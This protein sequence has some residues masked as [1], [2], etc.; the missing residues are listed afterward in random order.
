MGCENGLGSSR[1]VLNFLYEED[2]AVMPTFAN[3]LGPQMF[4]MAEEEFG[5]DWK[6]CCTSN[7]DWS[8]ISPWRLWV[9]SSCVAGLTA[10]ATK[11]LIAARCCYR[12]NNCWTRSAGR[13]CAQSS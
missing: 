10:F 1:E 6:N 8:F 12:K 7:K 13:P 4:W 9:K 3:V 5:I 2:L 11:A